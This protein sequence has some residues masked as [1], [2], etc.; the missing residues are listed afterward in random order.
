MARQ[1]ERVDCR[2]GFAAAL[3]LAVPILLAGCAD[4]QPAYVINRDH[5]VSPYPE[6]RPLFT[7][8]VREGDSLSL[9]AQRCDTNVET[10]VEINELGD[11][12]TIYPGEELRVPSRPHED[13]AFVPHPEPR[14]HSEVIAR[15]DAPR[16]SAKPEPHPYHYDA[17][18]P[19]ET[20]HDTG[21]SWWSWWTKPSEDTSADAG[22]AKFIWPVEGH[23]IE[24]FGRGDHGE[25]N[26]GINIATHEGTPFRAAASGTVTYTGNE[27]KGYGNLVLIKHD[28]GYVTAY[29]HA[30]SV[31][32]AR[33]D[34]VQKGQV[35]G[36][37][38]STGDVDR[39]QLHF[40]IR[41]GVQAVDPTQL[42]VA[43]RAS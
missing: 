32:V 19:A 37:V 3:F 23:V 36:T 1:V 24:G 20:N 8:T 31:R 4:D 16:P 5:S 33:G 39:P 28:G 13:D 10:I 25:R 40:E 17:P 12:H 26:D 18:A 42:L 38:G 9:I 22:T 35:I 27:L 41:R 21:Q 11:N 29:A 30:G 6:P 14:P 43:D 34:F 2:R 15:Y 7:V